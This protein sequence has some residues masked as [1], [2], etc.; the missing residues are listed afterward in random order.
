[1]DCAGFG[2][3]QPWL[4]EGTGPIDDGDVELASY[5]P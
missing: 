1:V 5:V 4:A 2:A 3:A